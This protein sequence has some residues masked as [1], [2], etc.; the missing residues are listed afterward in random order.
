M[1]P[2]FSNF[3][4]I[5]FYS[6]LYFLITKLNT[7][8]VLFNKLNVYFKD[9]IRMSLICYDILII[10]TKEDKFYCIHINNEN[11]SSFII[12]NDNSVIE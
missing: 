6:F 9:N 3:I 7:N 10:V 8:K 5:A 11:I 12:N 1:L 4:E 2:L